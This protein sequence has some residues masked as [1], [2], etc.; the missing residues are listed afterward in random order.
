MSLWRKLVKLTF[1]F[2]FSTA[3]VSDWDEPSKDTDTSAPP[4]SPGLSS[5]G[6][7]SEKQCDILGHALS[8][9]LLGNS[10]STFFGMTE[11]L[12]HEMFAA[13]PH[14]EV[15]YPPEITRRFSV[16]S[17]SSRGHSRQGS[18][19]G[20]SLYNSIT[21]RLGHDF[22]DSKSLI[23]LPLWN[24]DKSR[25]LAG[26][27]VWM[28]DKQR[29]LGADDLCYLRAFGD[30]IVAKFSQLGWS[31][32]TKS[33]SD[34][35]SSVS[36]ELRS[37][38]HGMLASAELLQTTSLEPAQRDMLTMVETCGLTLLDTMNYL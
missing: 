10:D 2:S 3:S 29:S 13:F 19:G 11:G 28:N 23:F 6:P 1:L 37:P 25:W 31:A 20:R 18:D 8:E 30:T 15:F 7:W 21:V 26:A 12:L 34:L 14:G 36:H 9:D 4:Q 24:W 17:S 27:I 33:K 16:Q 22:P 32:T 38:L 5:Q 35:L